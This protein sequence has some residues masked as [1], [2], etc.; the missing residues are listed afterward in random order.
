MSCC[1]RQP[2]R[3]AKISASVVALVAL[4]G[5]ASLRS[6]SSD[7]LARPIAQTDAAYQNL[8]V[9]HLANYNKSVQSLA[10]EIDG[11]T[12]EQMRALIH[13]GAKADPLKPFAEASRAELKSM[14]TLS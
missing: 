13:E 3:F 2:K 7:S 1:N 14:H 12:P 4:A 10:R 9:G 5:C 11:D 8:S 6:A